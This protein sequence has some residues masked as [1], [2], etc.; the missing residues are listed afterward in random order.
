MEEIIVCSSIHTRYIDQLQMYSYVILTT[1]HI[2][3]TNH[4]PDIGIDFGVESINMILFT[5][6]RIGSNKRI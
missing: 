5:Y 1:R 2:R 3:Q 4:V 6:K